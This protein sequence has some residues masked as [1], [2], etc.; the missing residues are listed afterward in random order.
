M[1]ALA[2]SPTH[3]PPQ[4]TPGKGN[5]RTMARGEV[6]EG[7]GFPPTVSGHPSTAHGAVPAD[8]VIRM[9]SMEE[10]SKSGTALICSIGVS[11][12]QPFSLLQCS[13]IVW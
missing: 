12:P 9:G 8:H 13:H 5:C 2:R 1:P 6:A 10:V 4:V 3:R 7:P 11:I